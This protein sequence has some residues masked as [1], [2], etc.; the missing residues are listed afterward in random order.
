MGFS[1]PQ[2]PEAGAYWK[3]GAFQTDEQPFL[4][5]RP[6]VKRRSNDILLVRAPAVRSYI[7]HKI[8][9]VRIDD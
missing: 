9:I 7:E 3:R 4:S 2:N 1:F 8:T 5:V 6:E